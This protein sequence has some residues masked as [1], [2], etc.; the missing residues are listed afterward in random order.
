ML[1]ISW[2]VINLSIHG[3]AWNLALLSSGSER[4]GDC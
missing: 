4:D 2:H 3:K 1:S